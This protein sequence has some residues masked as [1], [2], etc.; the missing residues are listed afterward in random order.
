MPTYLARV[1]DAQGRSRERRVKADDIKEARS[2]LRES[3]FFVLEIKE[4]QPFDPFK[5]ELDISFLSP[6]TVK[7]K[8]VFSR[9]FASLVNA[10]VPLVRGLGILVEQQTNPKMKKVLAAVSADVQQGTSLSEAMRQHPEVFDN[11]Y[12]AMIQAGEVG[13]VLDEVLNRLAKLLEDQARLEQQI[14]SAMAYP[15]AVTLIAVGVFFGMVLFLIPIFAGIFE[16]LGGQLPAFTQFMVN[17]SNW[18]RNPVNLAVIIA[19]VAAAI[20]GYTAAYNTRAGREVIDRIALNLPIFGDLIRKNA[21]ARFSRTF[22]SLS[23][24]GVPVLTSLEI[25]RDTAGNQII[26]NAIEAARSEI[27]AGGLISVALQKEKVFPNMAIQMI[28]VGEET[29]ELDAMITKVADF[30][31]AEVEAAVKALTS[32]M[33]PMM[34]VVLGG[35]VGSVLVAMYLPMFRIF[36]LIKN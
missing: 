22:G 30:Y 2:L 27:Q 15:I 35:L 25:V 8:A 6:V 26:A 11:L 10:G 34:I 21:V 18:M 5:S 29:G 32:I 12:V 20:F 16:S 19:L 33:E 14:K 24:S 17:L 7:D 9:Q 13:G 4:T 36:D 3:G 23:R 31:E 28:S 1:R